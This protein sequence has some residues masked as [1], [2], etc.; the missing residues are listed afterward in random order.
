MTFQWVIL[1][2]S[3]FEI[4]SSLSSQDRID[5]VIQANYRAMQNNYEN[6][7]FGKQLTFTMNSKK[8]LLLFSHNAKVIQL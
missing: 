3:F 2:L 5:S 7:E 1:L 6:L 4:S 8:N